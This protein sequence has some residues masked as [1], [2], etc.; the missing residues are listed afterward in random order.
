M[1]KVMLF[2]RKEM[3]MIW[4][5]E[6]I[7]ALSSVLT[8]LTTFHLRN[9]TPI[10]LFQGQTCL[11]LRKKFHGFHSGG[12]WHILLEKSIKDA[13][14]LQP[15]DTKFWFFTPKVTIDRVFIGIQGANWD[16]NNFSIEMMMFSRGVVNTECPGTHSGQMWG[17]LVNLG[18]LTKC[19]HHPGWLLV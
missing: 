19:A 4:P 13:C 2:H 15:V 18:E 11:M 8:S 9:D 16:N 5:P 1:I 6:V 10:S 12:R 17:V 7:F 3:D 14:S